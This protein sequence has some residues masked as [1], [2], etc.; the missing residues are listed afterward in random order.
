MAKKVESESKEQVV[1]TKHGELS[2]RSVLEKM[3]KSELVDLVI[4]TEMRLN[5][6]V[7]LVALRGAKIDGLESQVAKLKDANK[8]GVKAVDD[9]QELLSKVRGELTIA[10]HAAAANKVLVDDLTSQLELAGQLSKREIDDCHAK[11]SAL[12]AELARLKGRAFWARLL[13]KQ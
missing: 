3:R 5:E 9:A 13:N 10:K 1:V 2:S 7:D 8:N 4:S 12:E 6:Q 11:I